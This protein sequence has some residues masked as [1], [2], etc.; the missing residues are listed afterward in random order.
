MPICGSLSG[1]SFLK[2]RWEAIIV[3]EG[4]V[5]P[6]K[7]EQ[8]FEQENSSGLPEYFQQGIEAGI[9]GY[10]KNK[11]VRDIDLEIDKVEADWLL[12]LANGIGSIFLQELF[13]MQNDL[14]NIRTMMRMKFTGLQNTD[15]FLAGGYV[16]KSRLI[17]CLDIGYEVIGT[18][19]LCNA[20]LSSHRNRRK[21]SGEG[22]LIFEIR[23]GL[24]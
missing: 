3:R 19:L 12:K 10:Y 2:D 24:R 16:E 8:V 6:E 7:F 9:V 13:R 1:G 23:G 18:A 15:V 17:Q 11:N 14:I 22:R 21:L 20:L 5:L 4:N